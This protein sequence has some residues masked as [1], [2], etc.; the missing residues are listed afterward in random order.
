MPGLLTDFWTCIINQ[1]SPG[2]WVD[3]PCFHICRQLRSPWHHD[4]SPGPS[5][6][7]MSHSSCLHS[8]HHPQCPCFTC[9]LGQIM[10]TRCFPPCHSIFRRPEAP[11]D[12]SQPGLC[13]FEFVKYSLSWEY[14]LFLFEFQYKKHQITLSTMYLN[15]L[16][17]LLHHHFIVI[18]SFLHL[19]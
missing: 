1:E 9:C 14:N 7:P 15:T 18:Y 11:L 6:K 12:H 2:L 10:L 19:R 3:E 5:S 17:M 4:L 13:F 8:H 16:T